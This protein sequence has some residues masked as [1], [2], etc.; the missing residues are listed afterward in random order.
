MKRTEFALMG[1]LA[2]A[3]IFPGMDP[4]L[5]DPQIW[6]GVHNRFIV[7]LADCLQPL[8]GDRYITAIEERVFIE[9]P[10]REVV[11]DLIVQ[12]GR[13]EASRA[14]TAVLEIDGPVLIRVPELEI[15]ESYI[16][17]L[18]RQSG[19]RVVTVIEV[20]SPSNKFAGP[21]RNSYL[22]KQREVRASTTHLVE[23]DFLRAG[24]HVVSVPEWA[25]RGRGDYSSLVCVNRAEGLRD[26][27][28]A[29]PRGLRERLP[30]INVPLADDDPDTVLDLQAVLE[31][32]Y[33]AGRY[34][35]RLRYTEPCVPPL[36]P[37]EQAWA[38]LLIREVSRPS[39]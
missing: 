22:A 31:Q 10:Q 29:Y 21:G 34:R 37:D 8:L 2:V 24:P 23:I 32:T 26:Y 12:R 11:P 35:D 6:P 14:G 38:D 20:V 9:G 30:R 17:I 39:G 15:H 1:G 3:M 4:Y 27:Y 36:A 5:E 13:A 7:Y 25:V 28:E 19:Q 18:D 33:Q 16:N